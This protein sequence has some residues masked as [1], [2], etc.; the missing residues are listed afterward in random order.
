MLKVGIT[1]G[2]GVGKTYISKKFK[3]LGVPV[4]DAD[5]SAKQ[6]VETD[7]ILIQ[8]IKT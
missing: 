2:I 8:Q 1:G 6:L 7:L 3:L 5:S 4:Y